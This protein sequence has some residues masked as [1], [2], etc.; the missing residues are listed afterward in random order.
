MSGLDVAAGVI[1]IASVGVSVAKGL[2]EIADGIGSAG[3]EVR[4]C[5]A[6]TD[7][8]CRM[9]M[10]LSTILQ[11][12]GTPGSQAQNIAEDLLNVC[13]RVVNP[14]Q[15]LISRL[16]PLLVRYRESE[17]QLR[18]L[19]L[20]IQWHFRHKSKVS[21]Y[22]SA[23]SQLKATLSCLLTSMNLQEARLKAPQKV[24]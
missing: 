10:D 23:L 21:M 3:E 1:G 2:F 16:R 15:D 17:R 14:F 18:Q 4:L 8:F 9:L 19:S 6:D 13:E 7:M 20:R 11:E 22:Q 24:V 12:S 5:A